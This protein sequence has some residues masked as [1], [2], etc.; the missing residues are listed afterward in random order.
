[1]AFCGCDL[2]METVNEVRRAPNGIPPD[3]PFVLSCVDCDA[4]GPG[5]YDGAVAEG[6]ARIRFFPN[7]LAENFLGYCPDHNDG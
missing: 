2:A 3:V 4:E 7:S 6:W 5:S 1:M